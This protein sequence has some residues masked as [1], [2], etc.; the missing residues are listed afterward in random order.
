MKV[1]DTLNSL[2]IDHLKNMA[3][4]PESNAQPIS[5]SLALSQSKHI[6]LAQ[7]KQFHNNLPKSNLRVSLENLR[8]PLC[9]CF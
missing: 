1:Y 7:S 4:Q 6:S 2:I 5:S 9:S 8:V 3:N